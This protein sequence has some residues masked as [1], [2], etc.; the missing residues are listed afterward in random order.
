MCVWSG[1][2]F[3]IAGESVVQISFVVV[4]AAAVKVIRLLTYVVDVVEFSIVRKD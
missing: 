4:A 3:I 1:L 2:W